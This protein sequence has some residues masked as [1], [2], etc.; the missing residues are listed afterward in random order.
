MGEIRANHRHYDSESGLISSCYIYYSGSKR[1]EV[2]VFVQNNCKVVKVL[3]MVKVLAQGIVLV[4]NS[5]A[6]GRGRSVSLVGRVSRR[7]II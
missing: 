5:L 3:F 7:A 1:L 4:N 6:F 2:G